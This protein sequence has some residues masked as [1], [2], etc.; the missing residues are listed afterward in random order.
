M[1]RLSKHSAGS[2]DVR[3]MLE[4]LG[5]LSGG[6][7]GRPYLPAEQRAAPGGRSWAWLRP[8]TW[9]SGLSW[10]ASGADKTALI[11]LQVF[12]EGLHNARQV[13]VS[14]C[15]SGPALLDRD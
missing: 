10:G 13:Q 3:E 2:E 5:S 8:W 14:V 11:T 12:G 15:H 4:D 1:L 7:S 9:I 6:R